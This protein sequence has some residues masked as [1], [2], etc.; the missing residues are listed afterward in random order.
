MSTRPSNSSSYGLVKSVSYLVRGLLNICLELLYLL[1]RKFFFVLH[2]IASYH[3][4]S[5]CDAITCTSIAAMSISAPQKHRDWVLT[6][7]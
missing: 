2:R 7:R 5:I 4:A 3:R 1:A 6:Q